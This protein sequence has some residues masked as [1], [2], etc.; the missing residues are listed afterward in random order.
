VK[1]IIKKK[2]KGLTKLIKRKENNK[3]I[4]ILILA[5]RNK[6]IKKIIKK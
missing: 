3:S 5:I 1:A 4:I 2:N 6:R